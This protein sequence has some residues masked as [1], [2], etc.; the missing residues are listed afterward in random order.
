MYE[1]Q[2]VINLTKMYVSLSFLSVS[3]VKI[4]IYR[5]SLAAACYESNMAPAED[6]HRAAV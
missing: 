2:S 1:V 3:K 5:V 4:N 6:S